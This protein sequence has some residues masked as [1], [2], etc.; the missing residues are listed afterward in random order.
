[1]A[2]II[3]RDSDPSDPMYSEGPRSYSPH[4][5]QEFRRPRVWQTNPGYKTSS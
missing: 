3:W 1:M 4:W 5:A 2:K